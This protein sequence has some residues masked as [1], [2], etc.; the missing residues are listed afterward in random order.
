MKIPPK[1]RSPEAKAD[2][3]E[4]P[5]DERPRSRSKFDRPASPAR[6]ATHLRQGYGGQ[7]PG[8]TRSKPGRGKPYRDRRPPRPRETIDAD[9]EVA[10]GARVEVLR[11]FLKGRRGV[12]QDIDEKGQ[13]KIA[14]GAL[15]SRLALADVAALKPEG[16]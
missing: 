11:G 15:S 16:G 3:V 9:G 10:V 13:V 1:P 7:A 4:A 2:S 8:G 6:R 5:K 12:V 14:F